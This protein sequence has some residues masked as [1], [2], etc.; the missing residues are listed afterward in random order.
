MATDASRVHRAPVCIRKGTE[1][2]PFLPV[3]YSKADD[4]KANGITIPSYTMDNLLNGINTSEEELVVKNTA[5]SL[6]AGGSDTVSLHIS[7]LCN[8]LLTK[9]VK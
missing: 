9:I 7:F 8:H 3:Y 5:M 2:T 1:G 6:Y 4:G